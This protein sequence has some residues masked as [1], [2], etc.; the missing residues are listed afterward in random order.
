MALTRRDA[1]MIAEELHK[2]LKAE[3]VPQEEY[4][5]RKEAAARMKVSVSY[6]AHN[7]DRIP[8]RTVNGKTVYSVRTINQL[9]HY[10]QS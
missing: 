3:A 10:G 2:L 4:M 9:M 6:L 8:C 5:T 1:R 7:T